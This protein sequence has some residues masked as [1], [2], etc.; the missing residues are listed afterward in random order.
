MPT[1]SVYNTFE[2]QAKLNRPPDALQFPKQTCEHET[3]VLRTYGSLP[4]YGHTRCSVSPP[5]TQN[6]LKIVAYG[7]VE[8][9]TLAPQGHPTSSQYTSGTTSNPISGQEY[10]YLYHSTTM[11]TFLE[12]AR[13]KQ[14]LRRCLHGRMAPAAKQPLSHSTIHRQ[15]RSNTN[16]KVHCRGTSVGQCTLARPDD[17]S[18]DYLVQNLYRTTILVFCDLSAGQTP[19]RASGG[20]GF[21]ESR[22]GAL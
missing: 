14:Y 16:Q 13:P 15:S 17:K 4:L 19:K 6:C 12:R 1:P 5:A 10:L 3:K 21:S 20:A 18:N 11:R 7:L 22:Q 9:V 8:Q 2:P